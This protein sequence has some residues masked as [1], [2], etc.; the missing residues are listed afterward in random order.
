MWSVLCRIQFCLKMNDLQAAKGDILVASIIRHAIKAG[1]SRRDTCSVPW[2]DSFLLPLAWLLLC[3]RNFSLCFD[4][5][6]GISQIWTYSTLECFY[7]TYFSN[8][9]ADFSFFATDLP[10][11]KSICMLFQGLPL[12]LLKVCLSVQ[13]KLLCRTTSFCS[14]FFFPLF[15]CC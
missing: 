5:F 9:T 10:V 2:K 15:K 7:F 13:N 3:A 8:N 6:V 4:F 11:R 12:L 1:C 14:T